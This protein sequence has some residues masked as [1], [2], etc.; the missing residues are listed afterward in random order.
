MKSVQAV[1][2][3]AWLSLLFSGMLVVSSLMVGTLLS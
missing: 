2:S 3:A 1:F